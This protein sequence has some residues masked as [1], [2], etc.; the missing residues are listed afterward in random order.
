MGENQL[1]D[2][3]HHLASHFIQHTDFFPFA[4][5][6]FLRL[7]YFWCICYNYRYYINAIVNVNETSMNPNFEMYK[8]NDVNTAVNLFV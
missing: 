4:S 5:M 2:F 1:M 7:L 6:H 8:K 3:T